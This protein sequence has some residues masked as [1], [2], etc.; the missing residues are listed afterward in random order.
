MISSHVIISIKFPLVDRGMAEKKQCI[1]KVPG[2]RRMM[3]SNPTFF[4]PP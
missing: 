1:R 2:G 3:N 4:F